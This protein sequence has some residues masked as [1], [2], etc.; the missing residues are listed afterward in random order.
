MPDKQSIL[1]LSFS[2]IRNDPRVYRQ[3]MFLKDDYHL[4]VAGF[5][6]FHLEGVTFF[7]LQESHRYPGFQRALHRGMRIVRLKT[8]RFDEYYWSIPPVKEAFRLL[9]GQSAALIIAND[10][11]TLP[12]ALALA[13]NIQAKLL[14]DAHEYEPRQFEDRWRTRF[15]Y[16]QYWDYICRTYLSQVDAMISACEGYA[17]EYTRNYGVSCHV[18]TSAPFYEDLAPQPVEEQHIKMIYHGG[19]HPSRHIENMIYL[20]DH[21]DNRFTLDLMLLPNHPAYFRKLKC[22]ADTRSRVRLLSPVPMPEISRVGN[23]YDIGLY[24][25]SPNSFMHRVTVPNKL[26]EY[27]QSRLALA[28]WPSPGMTHIVREY[29]CGVIADDFSLTAMAHSL[30]MLTSQ[31]IQRYKEQSHL[32]ARVLSAENNRQLLYGLVNELIGH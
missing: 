13:R 20:V 27:I 24:L 15:M 28:I 29:G 21:L 7:S 8:R 16:H 14:L 26:F 32:A 3:I 4:S 6:E 5:G 12:L 18:L 2:V 25:L 11:N 19:T 23:R 1:I 10:L 9:K 22:F 30:N 31:D 17:Q